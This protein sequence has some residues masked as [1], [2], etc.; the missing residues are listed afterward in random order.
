MAESSIEKYLVRQVE[1]NG[2]TCEK[3]VSP[4]KNNVPD[5]LITWP[6]TPMELVEVKDEGKRP[7]PGQLRDHA[8]RRAMGVKVTVVDSK[9]DVDRY[10]RRGNP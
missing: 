5:R 10:C 4:E 8:R 7:R 1:R 2:G 3:F 6:M 9:A